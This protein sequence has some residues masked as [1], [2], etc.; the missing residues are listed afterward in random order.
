ML[1]P[2][3]KAR[4]APVASPENRI[5]WKDIRITVLSEKL[6]RLEKTDME[7]A[8]GNRTASFCDEATQTV[9]FRDMPPVSFTNQESD[10]LCVLETAAVQLE[11]HEDLLQSRVWLKHMD[12]SLASPVLL[13]E[14]GALPG[15]YR[16]LDNCNGRIKIPYGEVLPEAFEIILGKGIAS[17]TGIAVL[18]DSGSLILGEDGMPRPRA[19]PETDLYVFAYGHDYR[20]AV[21][22][23][24]MICQAPPVIPRFALGNWWSRYHAYTQKEYLDLMDSFADRGIPFTVAT[25]DMDWHPAHDLPGGADGWTGYSWNRE[26]FPDYRRFLKDLHDR[27]LRVT[28]N[29]HPALGVRSFEDQYP[30]MAAR[31]GVDPESGETVEFDMTNEDFINAYFDVL[32][33]PY[34]REGVDFWWIDWQ[35]GERSA[36]PGLDPL[37]AL[38]HFHWLDSSAEG[39]GLILSRYAGIGS[40]RYPLGFSG[41][42]YMTWDT[43]RFL[44]EFTACATNAGYTWWSHDIGGHM[45]GYKDDELYVRFI[46]FGV[47]S[48][49]NR[50]HS[51]DNPMLVKDPAYFPGGAGLIARDFLQLRQAMLP[52]LYTASRKTSRDGLA[53]IE[54]MYYGWPEEEE[55]YHC[56]GQYLFGQQMIAA[57]ITEKTEP[58]GTTVKEVWLPDGQWVDLFSGNQYHGGRHQ[59]VRGL[60]A[61]PLLL[62]EGGFFVQDGAPEGNSIRLPR[63][64]RVLTAGGNGSYTLEEEENGTQIQTGFRMERVDDHT[65]RLTIRTGR[66]ISMDLEF[67]T[68]L[69]GEASVRINGCEISCRA[70]R[71]MDYTVLRLDDIPSRASV[72]VLMKE[73]AEPKDKKETAVTRA[74]LPVQADNGQKALIFSRL[75]HSGSR[76]EYEAAICISGLRDHDRL[77]LLEIA[78]EIW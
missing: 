51:S 17:R 74:L 24:F 50:I 43:L 63:R 30:E 73:T 20:A 29:L 36:T 56:P 13:G 64:L 22:A 11:V 48:P 28:M 15:T 1:H 8:W 57:P 12:G 4:T 72:E 49:I 35:Q 71:R 37:W 76:M 2:H 10:S 6:F 33:R 55:A 42:T 39:S 53:L 7:A 19:N 65:L 32:H 21:Q 38:N 58:S 78:D 41:D 27:N 61:F 66:S 54:P 59:M 46:Q 9:W 5:Y 26:L 47:F 18:D 25:I 16:T 40:H 60:E 52:F 44:P 70:R 62:K 31:M 34:E 68:V 69:E 45:L 3:L 75:L 14:A 77:R 23:L 67:R